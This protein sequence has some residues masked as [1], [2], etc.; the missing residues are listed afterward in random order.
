[1]F[2]KG[3]E[4]IG[5]AMIL[6]R[7]I[8]AFA[9]EE[10]GLDMQ[11]EVV[12]NGRGE[13]SRGGHKN[14][15]PWISLKVA[16]LTTTPVVAWPEYK[17]F[18][19]FIGIGGFVTDDWTLY[20]DAL[21]CH[22]MGHAI[23]YQLILNAM[24]DPNAVRHTFMA[25]GRS[26]AG[27]GYRTPWGYTEGGHGTFF[28]NIYRKLRDRFVNDR[29]PRSA[30]TCPRN[31]FADDVDDAVIER[32]TAGNHPLTGTVIRINGS[33]FEVLGKEEDSRRQYAYKGKCLRTGKV[34]GLKLYDISRTPEAHDIIQ[35]HPALVA[36]LAVAKQKAVSR[37][38][39]S[40]T[41]RMRR[42]FTIGY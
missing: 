19:H 32:V 41:R 6:V 1:M 36:E 30:Y 35:K 15:K 23:Q 12:F 8:E 20:L 34:Y 24:K 38:Q 21:V 26:K 9:K 18:N 40:A 7:E 37:A 13:R 11:T 4:V 17:S 31:K 25:R 33:R 22:E 39:A 27:A 10:F 16:K 29:V 3:K 14:Q 2:P 42:S 5:R 28:Q